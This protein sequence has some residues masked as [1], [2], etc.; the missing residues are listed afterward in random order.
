MTRWLIGAFASAALF[1]FQ[2]GSASAGVI[3]LDAAERGFITQAGATNPMNLPPGDRDYLLGNCAL[4]S[5]FTTGGRRVSRL[6]RVRDSAIQ[7]YRDIR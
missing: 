3:A 6:F 5:C 1:T 4:A 2:A 7:R